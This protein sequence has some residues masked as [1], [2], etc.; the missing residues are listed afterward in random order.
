MKRRYKKSH[1]NLE[2][3]NSGKNKAARSRGAE[4]QFLKNTFLVTSY[5][6][7]SGN[8]KIRNETAS[9]PEFMISR[10]TTFSEH[11]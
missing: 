10:L 7:E 8:Q 1:F 9:F 6:N 5:M 4:N 11:A 2:L 3:M